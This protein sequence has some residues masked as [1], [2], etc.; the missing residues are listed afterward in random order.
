MD[1]EEPPTYAPT[2]LKF[3][4]SSPGYAPS[5]LQI[6]PS[7]PFNAPTSPKF[8]LFSLCYAPSPLQPNPICNQVTQ[9]VQVALSDKP[10]QPPF[11]TG[12]DNL[13][14]SRSDIENRSDNIGPESPSTIDGDPKAPT[15]IDFP[16]ATGST[17][18]TTKTGGRPVKVMGRSR[19]SSSSRVEAE[20]GATWTGSHKEW[21]LRK[22]RQLYQHFLEHHKEE[23]DEALR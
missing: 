15:R 22:S 17:G 12:Y 11:D 4:T 3:S 21:V 1:N 6:H 10:Q 14:P 13:S 20:V 2:P 19:P 7:S 5:S 9:G 18:V 23:G 8:S 16:F